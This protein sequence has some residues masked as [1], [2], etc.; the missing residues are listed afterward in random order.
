MTSFF[1]P[2]CMLCDPLPIEQL[3]RTAKS[4]KR[5]SKIGIRVKRNDRV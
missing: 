1:N 3:S 2:L 5:L 4:S